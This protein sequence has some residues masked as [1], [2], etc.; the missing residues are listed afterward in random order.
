MCWRGGRLE[1]V[2]MI[3]AVVRCSAGPP[4]AGED[5]PVD[6]TGAAWPRRD[7]SQ[8]NAP[9]ARMASSNRN[10]GGDFLICKRNKAADHRKIRPRRKCFM[11]TINLWQAIRARRLRRSRIWPTLASP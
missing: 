5:C 10:G 1:I 7:E 2:D 11:E 3:S 6:W 8:E 9:V 4:C